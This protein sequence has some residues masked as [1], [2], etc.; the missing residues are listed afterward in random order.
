M[1]MMSK[2]M[3]SCEAVSQLLEKKLRQKL[4]YQERVQ[5]FFHTAM[6][7]ACKAYQKQSL[8]LEELFNA[9]KQS[10]APL[11]LDV[12]SLNLEKKILRRLEEK[13]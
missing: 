6:C 4:T 2:L 5:L 7:D 13:G 3:L 11:D 12:D 1:D 9:K 10:N 8:L